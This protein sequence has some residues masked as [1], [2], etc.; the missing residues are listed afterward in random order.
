MSLVGSRGVG[1][2]S[3]VYK[4]SAL[5]AMLRAHERHTAQS[6]VLPGQDSNLRHAD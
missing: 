5:T 2:R 1:P 4:F 3:K 6:S